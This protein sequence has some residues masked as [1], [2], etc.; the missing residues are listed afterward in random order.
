MK[1]LYELHADSLNPSTLQEQMRTKGYALIRGAISREAIRSVL[2]DV[3]DVLSAAEW[4]DATAKRSD[5]IP[6]QGAA[7][8]DPDPVFKCVYQQVFNLESF[9]AIPHVP[10]LRYV[11]EMLVGDKILVHPKPI[12]RLIFPNCERLVVH[13]HQDYEFMGGDP[14]FFTVWIPLHDCP[15]EMGALR[16]LE[17]SH[18][19]GIQKHQRE[20]LHVPEILAN[21]IM[22]ED[23]VSG[24]VKAGDVL[25]FHSLTV[26][27]AS[28]NISQHLRL[29]IDCRFQDARRPL[30]P[31]NLVF[32]GESGKSWEKTYAAWKSDELK[33][34]WKRMPL[35]FEPSMQELKHL[36]QTADLPS[37]RARYERIVSQIA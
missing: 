21:D 16:I 20:N 25:I 5:R 12:G 2:D 32:G 24:H 27:A 7:F 23:W 3:T 34:Y 29:S 28:P 30:N 37:A 8:G 15:A 11:M 22:G 36:A 4:L 33:F 1:A 17:G 6:A 35:N 31:S 26:H 19:F 13:A 18:R 10:G 14:E 9:H